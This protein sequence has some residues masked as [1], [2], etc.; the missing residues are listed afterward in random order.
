MDE[1]FSHL[2]LVLQVCFMV[3]TVLFVVLGGRGVRKDGRSK[4][5]DINPFQLVVSILERVERDSHGRF[6]RL[7]RA[8][9][10]TQRDTSDSR[11][12]VADIRA[13]L[14]GIQGGIADVSRT[15]AS[16]LHRE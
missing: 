3:G 15:I 8:I 10:D 12:D 14:S 5:P 2:P 13:A 4:E 6:D 16:A 1:A 11:R 7:E 9:G